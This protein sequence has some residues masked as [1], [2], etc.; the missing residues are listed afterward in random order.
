MKIIKII[1]LACV[2]AGAAFAS[3]ISYWTFDADAEGLGIKSAID[4]GSQAANTKW[5]ADTVAQ[6]QVTD[7]LGSFVISGNALNRYCSLTDL[8]GNEAAYNPAYAS[9]VY[10]LELNLASWELDTATAGK[11]FVAARSGA[12]ELARIEFFL[13]GA[14]AVTAQWNVGAGTFRNRTFTGINSALSFSTELDFD[15][16]TAKYYMGETQIGLDFAFNAAQMDNFRYAAIDW[17]GSST[18]TVKIDSMGLSVIPEPATLGM[19]VAMG[20]GILFVRR[21]MI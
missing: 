10:R 1:A 17:N 19:V 8:S 15:N 16:N 14:D 3:P 11:V 13:T 18:E 6:G 20:T 2:F 4:S 21:L 12:T 9:G 5:S 7:G